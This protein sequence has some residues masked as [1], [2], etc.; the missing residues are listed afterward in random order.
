MKTCVQFQITR[1][2][3]KISNSSADDLK[4]CTETK[5]ECITYS[6]NGRY[7]FRCYETDTSQERGGEGKNKINQHLVVND[8][9]NSI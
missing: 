7:S 3:D 6:R 9:Q 4:N 8:G 5:H 1:L 2:C